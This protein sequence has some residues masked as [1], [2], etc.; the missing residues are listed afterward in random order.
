M[1]LPNELRS[2]YALEE[3][4]GRSDLRH[5]T[6]LSLR[7]A[8]PCQV[9]RHHRTWCQACLKHWRSVGQTAYEP[10]ARAFDLLSCCP[11]HKHPLRSTCHHCSRRL[12]P[13]GVF[14]RIGYC[15]HCGGWLGQSADD[16]EPAQDSAVNPQDLWATEQIGELLAILPQVNPETSCRHFRQS[17]AVY[18]EEVVGGNIVALAEYIHSPRSVLEGWLDAKTMPR[19]ESLLRIAR[20]LNVPISSFFV[21]DRSNKD[22]RIYSAQRESRRVSA[23]ES[24]VFRSPH[25]HSSWLFKRWAHTTEVPQALYRYR[26]E[27]REDKTRP[28]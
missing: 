10:L 18:L 9:F 1:A 19:L 2:G 8:L 15:Q 23:S 20:A 27:D 28:P 11:L 14:S 24:T 22:L 21:R 5:L 16:V 17:L 26:Q 12:S 6:L 3:A 13:L 25:C 4:T 7:Y